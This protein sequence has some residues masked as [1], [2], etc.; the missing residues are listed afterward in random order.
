MLSR[1]E[2]AVKKLLPFEKIA[3]ARFSREKRE[4]CGMSV[5]PNPPGRLPK[6]RSL[7]ASNRKQERIATAPIPAKTGTADPFFLYIW[8]CSVK[9]TL[10][11]MGLSSRRRSELASSFPPLSPV[12]PA[13]SPVIPALSPVIPAL[14]PVIPALSPVIPAK[15]GIQTV[16]AKP[17]IRNQVQTAASGSPLPLWTHKGRF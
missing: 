8:A 9:L 17:A 11:S 16:A 14:S 15:A 7:T 3:K 13:L 1:G 5:V 12:I 6:A 10:N 4:E 2:R